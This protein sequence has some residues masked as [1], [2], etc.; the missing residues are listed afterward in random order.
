MRQKKKYF[1]S[2]FITYFIDF[3]AHLRHHLL[4]APDI[5]QTVKAVVDHTQVMK[6]SVGLGAIPVNHGGTT[7]VQDWKLCFLQMMSGCARIVCNFQLLSLSCNS[8]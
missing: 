7:G 5:V 8:Q 3:I 1:I 2:Y 4:R 6:L